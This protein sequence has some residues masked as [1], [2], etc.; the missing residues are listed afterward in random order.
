MAR[1]AVI[2]A[3]RESGFTL[4]ELMVAF[5]IVA[6]ALA[7]VPSSFNALNASTQYR[8]A[9]GEVLSGLR[10]ARAHAMRSGNEAVFT[11]DISTRE[12][13]TPGRPRANL[14]ESLELGLIVADL[15]R[16]DGKGSIRFY[17]DGSSTG[18]SVIIKRPGGQGVRI[19]VDW[20]LGKVSQEP[21]GA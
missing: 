9:V 8:A 1:R 3:G 5:A 7:I 21:E 10:A 12:V 13:E 16:K 18:G 17:P 2:R 14:P 4:V 6:L 19:R 11:L 20:L 15:E